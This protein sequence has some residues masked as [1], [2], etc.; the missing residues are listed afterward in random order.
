MQFQ[1]ESFLRTIR[2][3]CLGTFAVAED[4]EGRAGFAYILIIQVV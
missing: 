4:D 2:F 1:L 3:K